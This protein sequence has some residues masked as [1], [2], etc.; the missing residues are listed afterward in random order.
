MWIPQ[1]AVIAHVLA[2]FLIGGAVDPV[3][4]GV[5]VFALGLMRA[6]LN[7]AGQRALVRAADLE[8]GFLRRRIARQ[9]AA[10]LIPSRIGG[11][12]AL[13]ALSTEK[14][15]L[16][17]PFLLRYT[18]ARH[19]V[20]LVPV[21]ILAIAAW[22]SWAVAVVLLIAG[23]LIPVFM[24][25]VGWAAQDASARQMEEV[26][27]LTD[28]LTDRLAA[29]S[30]LRLI[31]AGAALGTGFADATEK[32][33]ARTMAVLR[34]AFLSSTVLELFAA[35]GV[36]MVAV[37]VGFSLLGE[38][39]W[40]T[41]G[42]P[43]TPFGGIFL[44]LLV[45]EFFQPL[46]DLAAAWHDKSAAEAVRAET[47]TW[48]NDAREN[49]TGSGSP[50]RALPFTGLAT[51]GL[52]LHRSGDRLKFPDLQVA[53][54]ESIALTGPSGAG[55]TTL[56]RL[57]AGLDRPTGGRLLL[58][59]TQ[60]AETTADQ[61]RASIGWMPQ[62]PRFLARSLRHNITFGP[63]LDP[64]LTDL[65]QLSPVQ[66]SLPRGDPTQLGETGAG[67]S[68]GEARRVMLARALHH[69]PAVL[70]VDE[71]TADLDAVTAR[72]IIAGLL[73]H[74]VHGGTLIAATH[75]PNLIRALSREIRLGE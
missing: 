32:L 59:D 9:E 20:A 27:S 57:L 61:W 40:G 31:G 54:G 55:K 13:A 12:G 45:P 63:P 69:R 23:P 3:G 62:M 36:A 24:A 47:E 37:W 28:I 41:W 52:M 25:L 34:I 17:R 15:E 6:L 29:L 67:L 60:L 1:A 5:A 26:G 72:D 73:G 10:T 74:V 21:I 46:R 2:T 50:A 58:G 66:S 53:P 75:D 42:T 70:L 65:A 19:R 44:L 14:L 56:L 7:L 8:I 11:A 33:R 49:L 48:D 18:P 64:S 51:E 39:T 43:I 4:A 22:Y 35:L 68:G 30:D 16:L 71:P 38:I